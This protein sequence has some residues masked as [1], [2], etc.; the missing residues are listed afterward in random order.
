M[1]VDARA[2]PC[3]NVPAVRARRGSCAP[4][5]GTRGNAFADD[6]DSSVF[7]GPE[8]MAELGALAAGDRR[9]LRQLRREGTEGKAGGR[10]VGRRP[11]QARRR[12]SLSL[13]HAVTKGPLMS[14]PGSTSCY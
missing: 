12:G 14:T 13:Y 8:W 3:V 5:R 4:A 7:A 2:F 9:Q 11:A 10:A 6:F 1:P